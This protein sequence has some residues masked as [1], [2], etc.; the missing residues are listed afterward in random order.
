VRD[1]GKQYAL[2]GSILAII[3]LMISLFVRQRRIW[4]REVNGKLE[5]AGL[6]L[7]RLPGLEDEINKMANEIKEKK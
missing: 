5:I 6:A 4:V 1:P 7:N 2:I 3:G